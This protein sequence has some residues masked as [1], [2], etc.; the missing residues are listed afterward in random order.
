VEV[1]GMEVAVVGVAGVEVVI[2]VMEAGVVS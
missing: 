1:V 2:K